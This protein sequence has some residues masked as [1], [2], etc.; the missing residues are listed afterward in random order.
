[1]M[2]SQTNPRERVT[3][4]IPTEKATQDFFTFLKSCVVTP[5]DER[6]V[7]ITAPR[8]WWEREATELTHPKYNRHANRLGE[9]IW[10]ALKV[11]E[12]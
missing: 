1:M 11:V 7:D 3:L 9:N 8:A 6:F 5:V 2:D 4:R 12:V 10:K